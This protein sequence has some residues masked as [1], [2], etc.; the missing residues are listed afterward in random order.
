MKLSQFSQLIE[1]YTRVNDRPKTLIDHFFTNEIQNIV[2]SEVIQI[3]ISDHY[4]IYGVR[5][6]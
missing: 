3:G 1:D 4:L 2:S 6:F 5:R